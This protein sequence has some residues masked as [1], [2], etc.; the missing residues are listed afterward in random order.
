[1]MPSI[2]GQSVPFGCW[3]SF[4]KTWS[5]RSICFL[6][7]FKKGL[8]GKRGAIIATDGEYEYAPDFRSRIASG[9]VMGIRELRRAIYR[10]RAGLSLK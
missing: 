4:L 3:L 5:S 2:A 6:H 7:Q 8:V 9:I 1:M 10:R